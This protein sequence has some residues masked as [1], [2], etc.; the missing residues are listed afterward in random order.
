[1]QKTTE[2]DGLSSG[3]HYFRGV[4]NIDRMERLYAVMVAFGVIGFVA[5]A[6]PG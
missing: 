5:P 3:R 1:L 4:G 6:M 2:S